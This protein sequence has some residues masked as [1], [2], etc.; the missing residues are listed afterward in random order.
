MRVTAVCMRTFVLL[1]PLT[2]CLPDLPPA[3]SGDC[4]GNGDCPAACGNGVADPGELCLTVGESTATGG[5]AVF[6]GPIADFDLDGTEDILFASNDDDALVLS[7]GYGDGSGGLVLRRI[8]GGDLSGFVDSY[9]WAM[10]D[11]DGDGDPDVAGV[12]Y[13]DPEGYTLRVWLNDTGDL[14]IA[15]DYTIGAEPTSAVLAADFD[16]GA[17]DLLTF[18]E[19]GGSPNAHGEHWTL[20]AGDGA[21]AFEVAE[22]GIFPGASGPFRRPIDLNGDE[23]PDV[24][25][26]ENDLATNTAYAGDGAGGFSAVF[27]F[28]MPDKIDACLQ[29]YLSWNGDDARDVDGDGSIDIF[30]WWEDTCSSGAGAR[31]PGVHL[32]TGHGFTFVQSEVDGMPQ[33]GWLDLDATGEKDDL[34]DWGEVEGEVVMSRFSSEADGTLSLTGTADLGVGPAGPAG[35][36]D[37]DGDG[38]DDMLVTERDV[39]TVWL[40]GD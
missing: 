13:L 3:D 19:T 25:T 16:G 7:V 21:G 35:W 33:S 5:N 6:I 28:S 27:S 34:V 20:W 30:G 11:F 39:V 31:G 9:Q 8:D 2:G 18:G 4:A 15:H 10:A 38:D 26:F 32:S 29:S 36:A 24:L 14:W 22:D 23:V 37:V 17:V 40:V 1:L 12:G